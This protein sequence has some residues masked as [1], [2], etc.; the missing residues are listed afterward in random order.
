MSS[1]LEKQLRETL[2]DQPAP[3]ELAAGRRS[4]PVIEAALA[5]RAPVTRRTRRP[6]LRLALVAAL[7]A[8]GLAAALSPA[9]AE[10]GKWIEE[11]VGLE[12]DDSEATLA[13]FPRGGRLLA[14]SSSGA[15]VVD[16]GGALSR[17]GDYREAGWSP[18]GLYVIGTRGRR[19][20]AMEPSRDPRWSLLRPGRVHNPAWSPGD[21]YRVAYLEST[22]RRT[23]LRVVDGSGRLDHVVA[24]AAARVTPAWRPRG[25]G[26]VLTY[27]RE[28][29]RA[30][31]IGAGAAAAPDGAGPGI[32]TVDA[33]TGARLWSARTGSV[34]LKLAWT[35]DGRRLAVLAPSALRIYARDGRLLTELRLDR[36]DRPAALALHPSGRRAALALTRRGESRVVD[37]RLGRDPAIRRHL[38]SGP[39]TFSE[40]AWSP[41][42]RHLLVAWPEANQWLLIGGRRP[43]AFAGVSRELDPGQTGAGFPRIAGWCC[44]R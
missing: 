17:L 6:A 42:G 32:A 26:Y 37:V 4:W 14:V 25:E 19:L 16:A 20:T 12:A 35:R 8:I 21:G 29:A 2:A 5:E 15:W 24:A 39:G 36:G 41:D 40:L 22:G 30:R 13:G 9:G 18:R 34:P 23:S 3:G 38:F 28:P 7:L 33:D 44:P 43:H 1:L 31:G 27:A 11:R 10:V